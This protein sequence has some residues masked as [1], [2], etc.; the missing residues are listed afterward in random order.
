MKI[1]QSVRHLGGALLL[2]GMAQAS[3][4]FV[5]SS[6]GSWDAT[7]LDTDLNASISSQDDIDTGL[8][9]GTNNRISWGADVADPSSRRSFW[10]YDGVTEFNFTSLADIQLGEFSHR[11]NIIPVG[12]IFNPIFN[13][14]ILLAETALDYTN[15]N[16]LVDETY[17]F[18]FVHNETLNV[19]P[20]P[21]PGTAPCSDRVE[22]P[23][24]SATIVIDGTPY[25]LQIAGFLD[26][27]GTLQPFMITNE[28]A[29][30]SASVQAG[31]TVTEP[32]TLALFGLSLLSLGAL[33]RRNK[34]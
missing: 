10:Q 6:A 15:G 31:I 13:I 9:S 17:S 27:S 24:A 12:G 5:I 2:A 3:H 22:I 20:C 19:A 4:A 21:F 26:D 11:N 1:S 34:A 33:R 32:A 8:I 7:G 28:E 30:Q 23:D 25:T 29:L 16:F 18:E 14:D